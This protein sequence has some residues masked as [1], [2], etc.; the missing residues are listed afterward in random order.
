[1]AVSFEA[2][3]WSELFARG[4][5]VFS[6]GCEGNRPM[7]LRRRWESATR[8]DSVL[9]RA[10]ADLIPFSLCGDLDLVLS[11]MS[12]LLEGPDKGCSSAG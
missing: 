7:L 12:R 8:D 3:A 10:R 11:T 1:M 5:V 6:A 2:L 9:L 4:D